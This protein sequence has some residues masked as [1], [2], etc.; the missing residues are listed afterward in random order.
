[1]SL[2][3]KDDIMN[4]FKESFAELEQLVA[5]NANNPLF[6]ILAVGIILLVVYIAANSLSTN[7]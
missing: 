4:W 6:W 5:E 2:S 3:I 7:K 1:M